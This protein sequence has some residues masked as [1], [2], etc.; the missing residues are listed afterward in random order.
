MGVPSA[1]RKRAGDPVIPG[2]AQSVPKTRSAVATAVPLRRSPVSSLP[3]PQPRTRPIG[4]LPNRCKPERTL[5]ALP[6]A[7]Q[8]LNAQTSHRYARVDSPDPSSIARTA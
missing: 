5:S 7:D 1:L 6:K 4:C 8:Q 2:S 3:R